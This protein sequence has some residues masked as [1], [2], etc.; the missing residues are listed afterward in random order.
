M[1]PLLAALVRAGIITQ[2]DADRINRSMDPD[3]ARVW[4]EQQLAI[5]VQSGLN[6]QQA[7]LVDLLRRTNG[8]LSAGMLDDFWRREDALLWQAMRPTLAEIAAENAIA[9]SIRMGL[10]GDMWRVVN[11]RM[12]AWVDAYYV[13]ADAAM[14]GSIPNLNLT[15]RTEFARAFLEWQRGELEIG[16][17]AQGLPQLVQAITP[18]FGPGRSELIAQTEATRI[19]VESQRAAS[20]QDEFITHYRYLS[21]ADERVCP[22]C[23]PLHGTTVEKTAGGFR[24]PATGQIAYPP[25]HP[26]CRCQLIEETRETI[27]QPLPPEERYEWSAATY[28][29]YVRNQRQAQRKPDAVRTLMGV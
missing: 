18:T 15:S 17:T 7:R 20:E 27:R 10:E 9:L 1:N 6:A 25:L 3:A 24:N 29:D 2:A 5:A 14:V 8:T 13:N 23:G 28:A 22:Q 16:T 21:A 19:I 11:E 4:A 12:L 26:G